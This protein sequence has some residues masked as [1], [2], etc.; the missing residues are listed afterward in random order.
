MAATQRHP[1][2]SDA[3]VPESIRDDIDRARATQFEAIRLAQDATRQWRN[4]A[5]RLVKAGLSL[6]DASRMMGVSPSRVRDLVE[7]D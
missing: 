2:R 1:S 3:V 7:A 4:I 6:H 5:K